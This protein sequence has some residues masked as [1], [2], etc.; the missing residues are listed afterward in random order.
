MNQMDTESER[1][2]DAA[3]AGL[4]RVM[5][6]GP[7]FTERVLHDLAARGIARTRPARHRWLAAALW[8]IAGIG[9]G[10]V[11]LR[12]LAPEDAQPT[13]AISHQSSP[14]AVLAAEEWF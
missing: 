14:P 11:T 12:T 1:S 6:P 10:A 2:L 7:G 3:L 9:A 8:F 5:P 4:P 13:V